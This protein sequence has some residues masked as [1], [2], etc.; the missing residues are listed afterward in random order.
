[1]VVYEVQVEDE[2]GGLVEHSSLFSKRESA[3]AEKKHFEDLYQAD[4]KRGGTHI[5]LRSRHIVED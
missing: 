2:N 3:E 4:I 5:K 1:M